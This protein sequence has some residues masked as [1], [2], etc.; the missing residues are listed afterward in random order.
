MLALVGLFGSLCVLSYV[1]LRELGLLSVPRGGEVDP[2]V[3][4]KTLNS[5]ETLFREADLEKDGTLDYGDL[6]EL[7][8]VGVVGGDLG[9]GERSGYRFACWP[10]AEHPGFQWFATANPVQPGS[11]QR[12][13]ATNHSGVIYYSME[14]SITPGPDCAMPDRAARPD[15]LPVGK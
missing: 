15:V 11:G 8:R 5:A 3:A 2:I 7:A 10:S 4:L 6:A 14:A 13:F 1:L 12:Y 9:D